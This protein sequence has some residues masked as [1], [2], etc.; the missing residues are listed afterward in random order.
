MITHVLLSPKIPFNLLGLLTHAKVCVKY[1][2]VRVIQNWVQKQIRIF[3][4][5][6]TFSIGFFHIFDATSL[7]FS[8]FR[9]CIIV[10]LWPPLYSTQKLYERLISL[11]D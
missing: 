3:V 7:S 10:R 4:E 9:L 2:E 8:R 1:G 11:V 5:I 6:D